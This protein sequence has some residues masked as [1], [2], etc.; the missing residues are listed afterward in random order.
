MN[1]IEPGAIIVHKYIVEISIYPN[2]KV[3]HKMFPIGQTKKTMSQKK[4]RKKV[5]DVTVTDEEVL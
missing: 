2:G 5:T 3:Y 4:D 1:L